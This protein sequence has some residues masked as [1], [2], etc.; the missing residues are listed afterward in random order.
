MTQCDA[1]S[2]VRSPLDSTSPVRRM[3]GL[4]LAGVLAGCAAAGPAPAPADFPFHATQPPFFTLHW[5]LDRTDGRVTA[6]GV[7]ELGQ[8]DRLMDVTIAL[9]GLDREGRV[10]RLGRTVV[11]PRAFTGDVRWPFTVSLRATGTEDRF[12]VRVSDL[13]WKVGRGMR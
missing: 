1:R 10:V 11:Q 2:R 3:V 6:T 4:L 8:A 12:V 13:T 7:L 9:E 5:R